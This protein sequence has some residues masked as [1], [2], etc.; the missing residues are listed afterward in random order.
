MS[1]HGDKH[2]QQALFSDEPDFI[3]RPAPIKKSVRSKAGEP[4]CEPQVIEEGEGDLIESQTLI[5]QEDGW[6]ES[7]ISEPD[8]SSDEEKNS[9]DARLSEIFRPAT[10]QHWWAKGTAIIGCTI[11]TVEGINLYNEVWNERSLLSGLY[12]LFFTLFFGGLL[13]VI[14]AEIRKLNRLSRL[15]SKQSSSSEILAGAQTDDIQRYCLDLLPP[16]IHSTVSEP[17]AE[18]E[19]LL[20]N[21]HTDQ[22]ILRLY[23][24][25]VLS[26]KDKQAAA[27]VSK[28]SSQAA[29]MV[30]VSPYSALDMLLIAWRNIRMIDE[31]ADCYGIELGFS[32]RLKLLRLVAYNL[33]YAGASEL[34]IDFGL[35]SLSAD[36]L[37]KLSARA[38]QGIGAGLLSARL[39][40]KTIQICR[41][42]PYGSRELQPKLGSIFK[43]IHSSL[44]KVLP[45]S[46]SN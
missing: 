1:V 42:M 46:G 20:G 8:S 23:E 12:A 36:L 45:E 11:L 33:I 7:D 10:N 13:L 14:F 19:S 6:V 26:E 39:G 16:R 17:L 27:I 9:A 21:T 43:S 25:I 32:S 18:W 24:K 15:E 22:D 40:L 3:E 44:G 38:A 41:P 5:S 29:V 31:I 4:S 30:A 28:W 35:Q 2:Q 34:T 37:G